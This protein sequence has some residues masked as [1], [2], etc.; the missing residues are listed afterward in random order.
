LFNI[1]TFITNTV[2]KSPALLLAMPPPKHSFQKKS[3]NLGATDWNVSPPWQ[4]GST[5]NL[6]ENGPLAETSQGRVR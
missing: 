5:K 2:I 3:E 4:E 1:Q 6:G